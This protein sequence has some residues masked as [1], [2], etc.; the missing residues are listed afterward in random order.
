MPQNL[1]LPSHL[2][3]TKEE[4]WK[5]LNQ[6]PQTPTEEEMHIRKY[7]GQERIQNRLVRPE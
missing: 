7:I 4:H 6:L 5:G 2:H 1:K 3:L